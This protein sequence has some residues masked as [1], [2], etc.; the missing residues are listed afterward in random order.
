MRRAKL[1]FAGKEARIKSACF[2]FNV[3]HGHFCRI[4]T[5][6]EFA[7]LSRSLWP[8][9]WFSVRLTKG[10]DRPR[11]RTKCKITYLDLEINVLCESRLSETKTGF[12]KLMFK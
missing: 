4:N 10:G 9:H 2:G 6:N 8:G 11:F 7:R 5:K 3:M 12:V 1:A